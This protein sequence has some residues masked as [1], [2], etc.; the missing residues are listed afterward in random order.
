LAQIELA[1]VTRITPSKTRGRASLETVMTRLVWISL[2]LLLC[3]AC[4]E[5]LQWGEPT[6]ISSPA[7]GAPAP[8]EPVA[9]EF[10]RGG[11]P[12]EATTRDER[13]AGD[14][15][16]GEEDAEQVTSPALESP[17]DHHTIDDQGDHGDPFSPS[18]PPEDPLETVTHGIVPNPDQVTASEVIRLFSPEQMGAECL[19]ILCLRAAAAYAPDL[20]TGESRYWVQAK[21]T[22][23]QGIRPGMDIQIVIDRSASMAV[24]MSQTNAAAVALVDALLPVDRTGV[25][26]YNDGVST[27]ARLD[28]EQTRVEVTTQ[29]NAIDALGGSW[30]FES[31]MVAAL[32]ELRSTSGPHRIRR[33]VLFTCSQPEAYPGSWFSN[34]VA[35]AAAD[36]IY[37][38]LIGVLTYPVPEVDTLVMSTRGGRFR[39]VGFSELLLFGAASQ[40][41]MPAHF[42]FDFTLSY[43]ASVDLVVEAAISSTG[44]SASTFTGLHASELTTED[45]APWF[46]LKLVPGENGAQPSGFISMGFDREPAWGIPGLA[47]ET[48][49]IQEL[50]NS[51]GPQFQTPGVR[52]EVALANAGQAAHEGLSA[53]HLGD[54]E[55]SLSYLHLGIEHLEAESAALGEDAALQQATAFLE[56]VVELIR[57]AERVLGRGVDIEFPEPPSF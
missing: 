56:E 36:G 19:D 30:G 28:D 26:A 21:A 57:P 14:S 35:D 20:L 10:T 43:N 7:P 39:S 8:D 25:V 11:V 23:V 31:A 2:T 15:T 49:V 46:L 38:T 5:S 12:R 13:S 16:S 1:I 48:H 17:P 52:R 40:W 33:L 6:S 34:L 3:S 44:A 4:A 47:A 53:Y 18:Q 45:P 54:D 22:R 55:T 24:D 42:G 50:S 29:I 27:I 41:L 37:I 32:E 51:D 9:D